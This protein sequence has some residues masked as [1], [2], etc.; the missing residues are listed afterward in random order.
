MAATVSVKVA[1]RAPR[2]SHRPLAR[3]LDRE[4][5]TVAIPP[6]V[7]RL[8]NDHGNAASADGTAVQRAAASEHREWL[9]S[10]TPL[11]AVGRRRRRCAA[12]DA[13]LP[14]RRRAGSTREDADARVGQYGGAGAEAGTGASTGMEA[15]QHH[16]WHSAPAPL[17][18]RALG[19]ALGSSDARRSQASTFVLVRQW[20]RFDQ[21]MALH[22]I[23]LFAI[24]H[25]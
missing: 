19:R 16:R 24:T 5:V 11:S 18:R 10:T 2:N 9:S 3:G 7:G 4:R 8:R 21:P 22:Q 17:T 13:Q 6:Y 1:T 20:S 12:S 15:W 25:R 14:S 23:G